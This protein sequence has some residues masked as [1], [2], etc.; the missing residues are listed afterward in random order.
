MA[1]QT[2]TLKMPYIMP[3]QAQKHVTHNQSLEI[4]DAV[5]QL[6]V[7]SRSVSDP[8]AVPQ[9]GDRYVVGA[10]PTGAWSGHAGKI[11]VAR[12]GG[13]AIVPPLA[14]WM[15]WI[16]DEEELA[17]FDGTGWVDAVAAGINPAA[18][19][20]VNATADTVNR[21]AVSS[22]ASLF[23]HDGDDH[24]LKI[25]K[26]ST[27]DTASVLFQSG[28]SGRAEFGLAGADDFSVKV[29]PDGSAWTEAL[30]VDAATGLAAVA[31]DP[32]DDLG[33]ATKRYAMARQGDTMTGTLKV[34]GTAH[35]PQVG[36]AG[37][38]V[39]VSNQ[40]DATRILFD[41][42][43]SGPGGSNFTFRKARG[44]AAA[45]SALQSGDQIFNIAA[46]GFGATQYNVV[47]L[48]GIVA[49]AIETW[50]DSARG[51]DLAFA[52]TPAA[53]ASSVVHLRL[54]SLNVRLG[55]GTGSPIALQMNGA[56]TVVTGDRHF[57][58]RSYTV[59]E[60][61]SAT[62]P[63]QIVYVS[64]GS[65]NRRMAVSDGTNWRW[66]DGAVVS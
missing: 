19:V 38:I 37:T 24:R 42:Y 65:S 14:G 46:F 34:H 53:S 13:W 54:T 59:A 57:V 43:Q 23:S 60:L 32:T 48:G 16:G 1:D 3:S 9:E 63:G 45:P 22:A 44:S 61:P 28:F 40:A 29:S 11:A 62:L 17:V 12:P 51:M 52:V 27:G 49:R 35:T 15:A 55:D 18:L 5:V 39:H 64:D 8:P 30:T 50:T 66:P 58:L 6:A 7:L 10:T 25:N 2:P 47:S 56:N 36:P 4:L 41:N 21:L 26:A 33:I 31:G 20:G